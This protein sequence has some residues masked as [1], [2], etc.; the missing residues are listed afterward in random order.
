MGPQQIWT[1]SRV[2]AGIEDQ[3]DYLR[4]SYLSE[5]SD[6]AKETGRAAEGRYRKTGQKWRPS[7][8]RKWIWQKMEHGSEQPQAGHRAFTVLADWERTVKG[9]SCFRQ[10]CCTLPTVLPSLPFWALCVGDIPHSLPTSKLSFQLLGFWFLEHFSALLA[11]MIWA[12]L[13]ALG[14]KFHTLANNLLT[15]P[16][17]TILLS[18]SH[19]HPNRGCRRSLIE[20]TKQAYC[21][22][23]QNHFFAAGAT[24][25]CLLFCSCSSLVPFRLC[26]CTWQIHA[27]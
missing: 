17:S 22:R 15:P 16:R 5:L 14:E 8:Q 7:G 3:E 26:Y 19:H 20:G 4:L 21:L 23:T 18:F 11:S 12:S 1:L 2:E 13:T 6:L 24:I 25:Y 10:K 27:S 9:L